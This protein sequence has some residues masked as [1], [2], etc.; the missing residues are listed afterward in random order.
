MREPY[1]TADEAFNKSYAVLE[2]SRLSLYCFGVPIEVLRS[3][4]DEDMQTICDFLTSW[5]AKP[6]DFSEVLER[7]VSIFLT[8]RGWDWEYSEEHEVFI[9]RRPQ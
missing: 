1:P 7:T 8:G 3:L 5:Y 6:S 9:T 2:F 4:T